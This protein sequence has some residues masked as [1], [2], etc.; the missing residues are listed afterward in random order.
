RYYSADMNAKLIERLLTA[1]GLKRALENGELVLHYQPRISVTD[2]QTVGLEALVRWQHPVRGMISPQAFIP[3]AEEIGLIGELG[4]WVLQEACRQNRTWQLM[5]LLPVKVSVNLSA[6]QVA[7]PQIV[8]E[9]RCA[10][11]QSGLDAKWLE[12]ELTESC[13][14][15]NTEATLVTLQEIRAMGV[16]LS[17][18][19]FGTGYSSLSYLK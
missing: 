13:L 1:N 16:T 5:G 9:V 11:E 3:L 17:I 14:M 7:S 8:E 15:E 6:Q 12:L 19:D 4:R 18:D 2:G 10:L